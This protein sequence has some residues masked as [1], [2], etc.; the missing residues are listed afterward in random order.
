VTN[1]IIYLDY[2]ICIFRI[3]LVTLCLDLRRL[4]LETLNFHCL[5]T[6]KCESLKT[7]IKTPS[8]QH[9]DQDRNLKLQDLDQQRDSELQDQ[10]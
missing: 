2:V 10:D 5:I 6:V 3:H 4:G 1:E 8:F 7:K 9:T